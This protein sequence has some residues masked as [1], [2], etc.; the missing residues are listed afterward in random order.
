V[1]VTLDVTVFVSAVLMP[2]REE[3]STTARK[4][5][6]PIFPGSD[7]KLERSEVVREFILL[8]ASKVQF[9]AGG[10]KRVVHQI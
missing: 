6:H 3:S 7:V 9:S 1:P 5:V 2:V 10:L 8:L 4:D